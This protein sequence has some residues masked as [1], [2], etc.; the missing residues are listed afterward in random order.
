MMV[1]DSVLLC[2][3]VTTIARLKRNQQIKVFAPSSICFMLLR[4]P[5]FEH[6]WQ[7]GQGVVHLMH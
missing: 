7:L 6:H 2:S 3:D 5:R 4:G 1:Y